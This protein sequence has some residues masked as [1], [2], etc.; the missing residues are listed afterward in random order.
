MSING[1]QVG[2]GSA[3]RGNPGASRSLDSGLPTGLAGVVAFSVF[4]TGAA[5]SATPPANNSA[6]ASWRIDNFTITGDVAPV[7]LPGAA[8]LM[9]SALV[10]LAA[11]RRRQG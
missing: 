10:A 9:G 3:F 5:S 1:Q 4:A 8:W 7:P 11:R 6:N 2:S